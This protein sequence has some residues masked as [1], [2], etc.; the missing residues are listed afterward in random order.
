MPHRRLP[1]VLTTDELQRLYAAPNVHCL[2][3]LRNAVALRLLGNLGLRVGE[4]TQLRL[5]DVHWTTGRVNL[6][7]LKGGHRMLWIADD[8]LDLLQTWR[9]R[10]PV[11]SPYVFCTLKGG[12]LTTKY[13][14][15]AIKR[16]AKR[17]GL[18]KD[19]HPH[20]LRHTFATD[21][22]RETKDIRLVQKAL[23]HADLST[24]MIYTHLFD[25]EMEHAI[26]NLRRRP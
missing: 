20:M 5:P 21:I 2:T 22:Y 11:P 8:D 15:E 6:N 12:P 9:E 23:G 16:I 17:A 3:G 25:P 1:D 19:I 24:T 13:F 26:K 7:G 10:R 14:R 4:L 18:D